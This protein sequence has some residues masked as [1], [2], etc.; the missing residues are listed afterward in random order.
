M[1]TRTGAVLGLLALVAGLIVA[2]SP[3]RTADHLEAPL[4]Q[5]DGRLDLNDLYAFQS[6]TD[7]DKTVL[8]L[9]VNPGAGALSPTTFKPRAWYSF[10][11][12]NNGD[13]RAEA[14][15]RVRFGRPDAAGVQRMRVQL[16]DGS[17][18][19]GRTGRTVSLPDGG[20]IR[21]G[22][23][24]DPFF[25]D[26][27]AFNDQVK[28]AGGTRTFCDGQESDFLAGL[29]VSAIV[30]EVP[31]AS[32]TADSD[33]IAV[34]ANTRSGGQR[35]DRIGIPAVSTVLLKD[36]QK[37]RFNRV[38]PV[39]DVARFGPTVR[40]SLLTLSALDGTG[41][42]R[43]E[44]RTVAGLLLPDMLTL[45]T[46]SE[47]GFTDGPLN[48]RQLAEDV[49]DFELFVVTGGLGANGSPVLTSDCVDANDVDFPDRFPYLAP[50]HS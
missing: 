39:R 49:I 16:P 15:I 2:A 21:A 29:N 5:E 37:D 26:L 50:A 28:G 22:L 44:A 42:T 40:Q 33:T 43:A 4:V 1:K 12:D 45:D 24:D 48:G 36:A 18:I 35:V 9:T 32:L 6:P 17:R 14:P 13:A 31:T 27:V 38:L 19:R 25:F 7:P 23:F 20:R 11:V 41:Y 30:L 46:S 8:I 3:G 47:T 34:W 10:M